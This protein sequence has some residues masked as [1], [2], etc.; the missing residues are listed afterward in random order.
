VI[1]RVGH[2]IPQEAPEAFAR[3]VLD[4]GAPLRGG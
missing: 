1:P 2:N 4:L 3:A